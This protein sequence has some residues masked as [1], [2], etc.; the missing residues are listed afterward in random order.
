MTINTAAAKTSVT[1]K[2][3][4]SEDRAFK[5]EWSDGH[6]SEF[7]YVWLRYNCA[8]DLCGDLDSGIGTVMMADIPNDVGPKEAH[9]DRSGDLCVI[10]DYDGHESRFNP[11]WLRNY[12][13]SETARIDRR[14]RPKLWDCSFTDQIPIFD[15]DEVTQ[16]ES[17][18][19]EVFEHVNDYGFARVSGAPLSLEALSAF[20]NLFGHH[21]TTDALGT[22]NDI[23]TKEKK[24]FFTDVPAAIPLH[25]D[26]TYRHT[27]MGL[28]FFHC[29]KTGGKGG[30]SLLADSFKIAR[31]LR[32]TEP[33]AFQLLST[34]PVQFYR[35]IDGQAAYFTEACAISVD[36]LGEVVGFRYANRQTTAPLDLPSDLV[37]PM[38]DAQRILSKLMRDPH[39][40]IQF[41]LKPGDILIY[42]NQRVLHGRTTYDESLG[43]RHLRSVEVNREEFHNRLRL[44]MIKLGSTTP[45]NIA[46]MRGALG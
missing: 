16:N 9:I 38:H 33:K 24:V 27:P 4:S 25:S 36:Y 3:L 35:Y 29:L 22:F 30:D 40:Q 26:Q 20:S 45:K 11:E 19:L 13:Y 42:D 2:S 23:V 37:E 31:A 34:V 10:W 39:F 43:V 6:V 8:C 17:S 46:L 14:H 28:N 5:V 12:C 15:H 21:I 7:H 41:L 1:L 44:L 32:E 18:L